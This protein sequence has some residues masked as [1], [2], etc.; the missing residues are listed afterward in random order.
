MERG[1]EGWLLER[2][3]QIEQRL[4]TR[5]P[6]GQHAMKVAKTSS[7]LCCRQPVPC[8]SVFAV[9]LDRLADGLHVLLFESTEL[10]VV[11]KTIVTA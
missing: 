7:Q 2:L 9:I 11:Q 6:L 1:R 5:G 10:A 4:T 3:G 8:E